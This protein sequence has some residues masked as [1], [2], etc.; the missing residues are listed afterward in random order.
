MTRS[1]ECRVPNIDCSSTANCWTTNVRNSNAAPMATT[2]M[3]MRSSPIRRR[4]RG[5][6]V[7]AA[8]PADVG[9]AT[10]GE[11]AIA[12]ASGGASMPNSATAHVHQSS[13]VIYGGVALQ[14]LPVGEG[15]HH[16]ERPTDEVA[17]GDLPHRSVAA[18]QRTAPVVAHHEDVLRFDDNGRLTRP[19]VVGRHDLRVEVR[20]LD[21]GAIHEQLARAVLDGFAWQ[22][23][24]ALDE[25]SFLRV[26]LDALQHDDVATARVVQAVAQLVDEHPVARMQRGH[27]R[28]ALDRE[29]LQY[30]GA[31]QQRG[32]DGH[33]HDDDPLGKP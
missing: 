7:F 8:S 23:H 33:D 9:S 29:L 14:P 15:P 6:D 30:V 31:D 22:A 27:H 4:R 26:G 11:N 13:S 24:D 16:D 19:A 10:G 3:T 17:V 18:V 12:G 28:G 1:P 5:V 20:L 25:V 32:A 2:A 21:Q